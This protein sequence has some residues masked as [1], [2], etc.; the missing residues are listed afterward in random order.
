[1][2]DELHKRGFKVV[3]MVPK[4]A[5]P[6]IAEFDERASKAVAA[7]ASKKADEPLADRTMVWTMAPPGKSAVGALPPPKG[8]K[9]STAKVSES[10]EVLPWTPPTPAVKKAPEPRPA[11]PAKAPQEELPWQ[12]R[13]FNY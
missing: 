9:R 5:A 11:K 3:H 8:G 2:L 6:T 1:M 13:I 10:D 7:K 4:A 12:M